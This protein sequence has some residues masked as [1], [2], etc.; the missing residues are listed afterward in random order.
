MVLYS[1][2]S[3]YLVAFVDAVEPLRCLAKRIQNKAVVNETRSVEELGALLAKAESAFDMQ[4]VL[5]CVRWSRAG[6]MA[7]FFFYE[8]LN[9][10][11]STF[12]TATQQ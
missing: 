1:M 6:G 11:K 2:R 3:L 9:I 5:T 12:D 7:R 10:G 4:Q 8:L